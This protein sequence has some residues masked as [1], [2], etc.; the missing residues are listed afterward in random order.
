MNGPSARSFR[1]HT[2]YFILHPL[3]VDERGSISL[4]TVFALLLL[5][6]LLGMVINVGRQVDNKIKLQNA[7]DAST[8]SGGVV[9]ARGMNTLAYTNHMLTE[10]FALTAFMREARDRHAEAL[11]P[12]ILAT[13]DSIGP[14]LAK[15]GFQKFDQLGPAIP[16]K[17]QAEQQM[18]TAYGDWMA[19]SS[20]VVLPVLEDILAQEM[21]PQ[22]QRQVVSVTPGLAQTAAASIANRNTGH[23]SPRDAPRGPVIGVFWRTIVDP[24]GGASE[25]LQGTL[26]AIDPATDLNY[27]QQAVAARN[28]RASYYLNRWNDELMDPFRR[29]AQMSQFANLW[30]SFT[31][32]QL[33]Q[34]F[35]EYPDT[36]LPHLIRQPTPPPRND[37]DYVLRNQELEQDYMFVG[38][39]YRPK[40]RPT[41][42][43]LF[44]D[45]LLSDNEAFAQGMLFVP[46]RRPID[47]RPDPNRPP[48]WI[49]IFDGAPPG[50]DLWNENWSFQLVPATAASV[51]TILQTQPQMPAAAGL[52]LNLPNLQSVSLQDVQRI[53]TH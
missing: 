37:L 20:A 49:L 18:V 46:R 8:Y 31:C 3:H 53:T 26:P 21:V 11:V 15:S 13:W 50:W 33:Q 1:S 29:Y 52:N 5:T 39:A 4:A 7:A 14:V 27:L 25:S 9:L 51:P 10:V 6:M 44:S 23:P 32:G 12:P 38:V 36:N 35:Q 42:P 16:Q 48:Y 24:V 41:M 43:R 30:R 34:L 45:S 28:S 19:A 17:T 2:S 40:L 47:L 22:L